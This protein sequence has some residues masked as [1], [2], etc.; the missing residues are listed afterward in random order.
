MF[1]PVILQ[2]N[3]MVRVGSNVS[4]LLKQ[5]MEM[6]K[7]NSLKLYFVRLNA[8]LLSGATG[9]QDWVMIMLCGYIHTWCFMEG[10]V[11]LF[12]L[13]LIRQEVECWSQVILM[14]S[15]ASVF[16]MCWGRNTLPLA[17]LLR[18]HLYHVQIYLAFWCGCYLIPCWAGGMS[19]KREWR[20]WWCW[21]L[22]LTVFLVTLWGS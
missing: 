3:H 12:V 1:C 22:S 20:P 7:L 8:V 14:L 15:L 2:R 17:W 21:F 9:N 4:R 19:F 16:L 11:K 13:L 18:M 6:G 5:R 10:S